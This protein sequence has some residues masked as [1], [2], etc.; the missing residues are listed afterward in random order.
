MA[1]EEEGIRAEASY[2]C[3]AHPQA[4]MASLESKEEEE[5]GGWGYA[6]PLT[7]GTRADTWA[8]R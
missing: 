5:V 4:H 7:C 3:T 6:Q 1:S 2:V 8:K